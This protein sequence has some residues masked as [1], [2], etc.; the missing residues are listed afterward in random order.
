MFGLN[1]E[2]LSV[3]FGIGCQLTLIPHS[4]SSQTRFQMSALI[5]ESLSRR[6]RY[7]GLNKP[8]VPL[9]DRYAPLPAGE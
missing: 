7:S 3:T 8:G 1:S 6:T 9:P 4:L 5:N 2:S